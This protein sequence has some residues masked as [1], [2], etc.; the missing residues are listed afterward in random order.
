[1]TPGGE[2]LLRLAAIALRPVRVAFNGLLW[3]DPDKRKRAMRVMAIILPKQVRDALYLW[4]YNKPPVSVPVPVP[5][6]AEVTRRPIG[7]DGFLK[8]AMVVA[9]R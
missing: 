5:A 9:K 1:M 8:L 7:V 3:T 4:R 6:P 2:K